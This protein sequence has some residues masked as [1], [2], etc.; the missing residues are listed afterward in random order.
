MESIID[1]KTNRVKS[2]FELVHEKDTLSFDGLEK[3]ARPIYQELNWISDVIESR[4]L[5]AVNGQTS[6]PEAPP[7]LSEGVYKELIEQYEFGLPERVVLALSLVEQLRPDLLDFFL[8]KKPESDQPYRL[9]GGRINRS[10]LQ[11]EPSLRT[12]L[13]L[14]S[15]K[16]LSKFAY[17]QNVLSESNTLF[18]QQ[19]VNL[20]SVGDYNGY[21]PNS[22][23]KLDPAYSRYITLGRP[24]RLDSGVD[25]P[26]KLLETTKT[27]EDLVLKQ[28]ALKQLEPALN[29]IKVQNSLY[30]DRDIS[31]S[32]K[33]GFVMLLYGP[34]GTGKTLTASIIGNE[35]NVPVYQ[36]DS[37]LVVSK[38]IGETEKNLEKL[39]QRLQG[40]NCILFFDEADALFGKRTEVRDAKDR[41][42]N[43]GVAYLLQRIESFDG[44]VILASNYEKNFDD[45][46]SRRILTKVHLGRPGVEERKQLWQKGLPKGYSFSSEEYLDALAKHFDFT[47][48]NISVVIKMSIEYAFAH[49]E[50]ELSPELMMPFLEIVGR[51]VAG[52][53]FRPLIFKG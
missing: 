19:I 22:L 21:R 20:Y 15:G 25:F 14:L 29:Y 42:A 51:E 3:S 26:A 23:I 40:K 7:E 17:Y 12:A 33:K 36:V 48:A 6:D 41:Y 13:F 46:F 9:F 38:Y 47:G 1:K 44:L 5:D 45:A 53:N 10:T 32:I 34:P 16:D 52:A 39:F 2:K 28:N 31:E 49:G 8:Q 37:S 24:P 50:K 18:T 4:I 11:F 30:E 43:Q 27:F 35:S